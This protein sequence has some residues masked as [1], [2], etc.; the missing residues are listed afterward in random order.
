VRSFKALS[1]LNFI[2][3]F[4]LILGWKISVIDLS[5]I[6]P[7]ILLLV[8]IKDFK[9]SYAIKNFI[10][11]IILLCIY[12][13]SLQ[14]LSNNIDIPNILRLIR[15]GI[16]CTLASLLFL[17]AN[18]KEKILKYI[19]LTSVINAFLILVAAILPSVNEVLVGITGNSKVVLY[20]SSGLF[21]GYDIAGLFSVFCMVLIIKN[22][23]VFSGKLWL[24][25]YILLILSCVFSSRTSALLSL[26][27]STYYCLSIL[28]D[29]KITLK[30]KAMVFFGATPI[31][32]G[33]LVLFLYVF[34]VSTGY[35][36]NPYILSLVEYTYAKNSGVELSSMFFL[37]EG[38]FSFL[39][40]M[41]VE[42]YESDSGFVKDIFRF[43]LAGSI[44]SI[45]LYLMI[46]ISSG[47][48][49][50][51]LVILFTLILFFNIKN[52]YFFVRGILPVFIMC[53]LYY[54]YKNRVTRR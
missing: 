18:N 2:S 15:S 4:F 41:G 1:F 11:G 10:L 23:V 52:S 38:Q 31:F 34:L 22:R 54:F 33:A 36:S 16:A 35:L 19:V 40:G 37:P 26:L 46:L 50:G 3:V 51:T 43:G 29:K 7:A 21:S 49:D 45:I 13:T 14:I 20:R 39:F 25:F 53:C 27:V 47:K 17:N 5:I 12:Q 30:V 32:G 44:F 28:L 42:T 6:V 8:S 9:I 24:F 48:S